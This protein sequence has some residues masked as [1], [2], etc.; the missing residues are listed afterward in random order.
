[1]LPGGFVDGA[2]ETGNAIVAGPVVEK[3]GESA[4]TRDEDDAEP[5]DKNIVHGVIITWLRFNLGRFMV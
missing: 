1:M 5:E 4:E 2:K 3:M